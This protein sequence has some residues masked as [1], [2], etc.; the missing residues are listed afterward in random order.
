MCLTTTVVSNVVHAYS[1]SDSLSINCNWAKDDFYESEHVFCKLS[2]IP[3]A[4]DGL[5]AKK[6]IDKNTVIAYYNGLYIK[7]GENYKNGSDDYQIYMD[8]S[9]TDHS[10]YIDVPSNAQ[11]LDSYR[12]SLG[13]KA[14][15]SFNPNS[16]YSVAEHPVFGLIVCI[17]SIKKLSKEEEILCHYKYDISTAPQWYQDAWDHY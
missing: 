7:S 15:H 12:A 11:S 13:H 5:F 3:N 10:D 16:E 4:S 2:E 1:P 6:A 9:N 8:W 14:N 17:K